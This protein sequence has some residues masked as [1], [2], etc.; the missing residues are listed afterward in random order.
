MRILML[1]NSFTFY[2]DMPDLLAELT[3]AEVVFHTR[4]GARLAEH[5]NLEAELGESDPLETETEEAALGDA[6]EDAVSADAAKMVD[7]NNI[8]AIPDAVLNGLDVN[9]IK[10]VTCGYQASA[11][12]MKDGTLYFRS[13]DVA[14]SVTACV[15]RHLLNDALRSSWRIFGVII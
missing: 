8:Q 2:N 9:E 6:A 4:G 1:G 11:I 10:K 12:L 7:S 15:D 3:G 14:G 5:L 13:L